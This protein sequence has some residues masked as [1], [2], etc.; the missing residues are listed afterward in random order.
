M[1]CGD[2]SPLDAKGGDES[3]HSTTSGL[4]PTR[5]RNISS[6]VEREYRRLMMQ[7]IELIQA[8]PPGWLKVQREVDLV[9]SVT[10]TIRLTLSGPL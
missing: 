10:G 5:L 1:E 3:P 8:Q 4:Q 6:L 7:W 2:S 9:A